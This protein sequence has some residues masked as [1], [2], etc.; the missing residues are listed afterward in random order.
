MKLLWNGSDSLMLITY[1][2]YLSFKEKV[3]FFMFRRVVRVLEKF[4]A[5][6]YVNSPTVAMNLMLFGVKKPIE[7]IETPLTHN[8]K[9]D[10]VPHDTFNIMYTKAYRKNKKLRDWIYGVDLIERAIEHYKGAKDIKFIRVDGGDAL[11]QVYPIIDMYIRPNRHD[12]L[13]RTVR[14]CEVQG[15][16]YYWSD[17]NPDYDEMIKTIDEEISKYRAV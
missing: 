13:A 16:P 4:C 12:G 3:F 2:K 5:G 9:Y 7:Y 14:E 11:E 10:K 1:T 6:H 17:V 8:V 15:I